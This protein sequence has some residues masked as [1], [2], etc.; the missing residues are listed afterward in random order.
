MSNEPH[1]DDVGNPKGCVSNRYRILSQNDRK[2]I[3]ALGLWL[4]PVRWQF[5]VTLEF[6]RNVRAET[7]AVRL[8]EFLNSVEKQLR[9]SVCFI[10]GLEE[11]SKSG[12]P[13]PAHF[14]LLVTANRP[15]PDQLLKKVWWG[16]VGHGAK[17]AFQPEGDSIVVK[18]ID[19]EREGLAYCLKFAN[20]CTGDWMFKWLEMFNPNIPRTAEKREQRHRRRG[21]ARAT[22]H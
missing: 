20:S 6:P 1:I 14:H 10:G 11:V 2:F 4:A 12:I 21:A 15:I 7:A 19:P 22:D 16:M 13:V 18:P 17:S 8:R 3:D 5:F 9:E